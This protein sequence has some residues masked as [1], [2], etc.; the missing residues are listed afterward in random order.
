MTTQAT[1]LSD[2]KSIW[3]QAP[4]ERAFSIFTEGIGGWWPLTSHSLGRERAESAFFEGREGGRVFERQQDGTE[5]IWATVRAWEP[6]HRVLLEWKVNPE[7]PPTELEVRFAPDGD[8]TRVDLEHRG[9]ER[10]GERADSARSRY[11]GGWNVVL[12]GYV[13]AM[14]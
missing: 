7:N 11:D 13:E 4:V 12:G 6:P 3:V 5:A 14:R 2:R 8:G 9:W 10:Y 1:Q